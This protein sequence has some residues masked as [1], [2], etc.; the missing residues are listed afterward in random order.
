MSTS[1]EVSG[2][3]SVTGKVIGTSGGRPVAIGNASLLE[4]LSVDA[5]S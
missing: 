5:S 2:F 3:R 1:A 4:E